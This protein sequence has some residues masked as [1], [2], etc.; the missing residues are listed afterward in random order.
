M[1]T[2]LFAAAVLL[3]SGTAGAWVNGPTH[4]PDEV[5][6]VGVRP[7]AERTLLPARSLPAGWRGVRDRDTGVVA[8]LWG[9]H[10]EAPGA[11]A[12]PKIAEQAARAFVAAQRSLLAPGLRLDDLVLVANHAERGLRTISFRQTWRGAAVIGGQ[13]AV[14][15][16]N[17][18]V[19]AATSQIVPNVALEVP[20][21]TTPIDPRRVQDWIGGRVTIRAVG[22]RVVLPLAGAA[23]LELRIADQLEVEALDR[24]GRWDVYVGTDGAPLL[25]SSR[26]RFASGTLQFDVGVR[27]PLGARTAAPA[28]SVNVTADGTPTITAADGTF[29]WTGTLAANVAPGLVGPFI[30]I[31]NGAGALA[32]ASLTAQPGAPVVWSLAT[33]EL[34]DAQLASFVNAT[35]SK[36]RARVLLP[37]L[38]T[39]LDQPLQVTVNE[40]S[41]CNA[42]STGDDIHFFRGNTQ[43]ENTGRIA[44]VVDHEFGHSVHF[45]AIIPGAGAF[46]SALSEGLAD[47]FAATIVGDHALGRGFLLNDP[48]PLRDLDPEGREA[49]WPRDKSADPHLTGLIIG[50]TLW[51]LRTALITDLGPAAG[52]AQTDVIF[53]G[54]LQ[55]APDLPGAFMAAQIADDDDGDLGNGT[56]HACAIEAAFGRHGLA[57]PSFLSTQI[58]PPTFDGT[59]FSVPTTTPT[60]TPCPVPGVARITL[61]YHDSTGATGTVNFTPSGSTWGGALPA[62]TANRLVFYKIVATLEDGATIT[63]PDNPA[64]PEYQLFT[65]TPAEIWCERMDEDPNWTAT[66]T[67][68][69]QWATPS[70]LSVSGDPTLAHTGDHVLGTEISGNGRYPTNAMTS[71]STPE[72]QTWMYDEVHLQYWRW[73]AVEDGLYDQATIEINGT[74][75]WHN[76]T[77]T[78]GSLDHVDHEWRFQDVNVTPLAGHAVQARWTMASDM[79]RELGGWTIDDVCLVGLGKHP[80]CGDGIL[81]VR[82]DCDDGNLTGGDGCNEYCHVDDGGCCSAGTDPSGPLVLGLGVLALARRRRR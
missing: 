1:R 68:S 78:D 47:F 63:Y 40:N 15:I 58:G 48:L 12:D 25:R 28:R 19:F 39:W 43:C 21:R 37:S 59:R 70:P 57:G 61:E 34:G 3:A 14:M 17:D 23:G 79:S 51:D 5:A 30:E 45:H 9:S 60:G 24:P 52:L 4:E 69:W 38:A 13:L 46:N 53:A 76:A 22:P 77:T 64:D 55:M 16:K 6:A 75:V 26:L 65:G 56:P 67:T 81:D 73:L 2:K 11:S 18:R 27:Y 54:V 80:V 31:L 66:G 8:E 62:L 10:V 44:D 50:G 82:E 49:I 32:T 72:I 7:R 33:S 35:T 29:G 20:A 42:Y 71:I 41:V 36:A 74:S